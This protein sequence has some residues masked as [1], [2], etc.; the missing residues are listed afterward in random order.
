M[1]HPSC[2][3]RVEEYIKDKDEEVRKVIRNLCVTSSTN[4][5]IPDLKKTCNPITDKAPKKC[6]IALLVFDNFR[7]YPDGDDNYGLSF[8]DSQSKISSL[9]LVGQNGSG[10]STLYT[11]LEKIYMGYSSYSKLLSSDPDSYLSFG[12]KKGTNGGNGI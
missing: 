10:K 12:F 8:L 7:T 2:L 5:R 4:L 9:L 11:A 3:M 1:M 6:R